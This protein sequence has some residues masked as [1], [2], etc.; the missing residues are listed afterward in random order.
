MKY[1][2]RTLAA[3][4]ESIRLIDEIV[5][6]FQQLKSEIQIYEKKRNVAKT[7]GTSV[8]VTGAVSGFIGIVLTA[9]TGNESFF[10]TLGAIGALGGAAI[11]FVVDIIDHVGSKEHF[12][13]IN[14][15]L[16]RY[17]NQHRKLDDLWKN[18]TVAVEEM[19][20]Q[21]DIESSTSLFVIQNTKD[22]WGR[23]ISLIS[24]TTNGAMLLQSARIID[25]LKGFGKLTRTPTGGLQFVIKKTH[26]T[27][28]EIEA[29]AKIVD[30]DIIRYAPSVSE[31]LFKGVV[32]L[33]GLI[34]SLWEVKNLI[35]SWIGSHPTIQAVDKVVHELEKKR[36]NLEHTRK[37]II[38]TKTD[39]LTGKHE[40]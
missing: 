6:V 4:E 29:L 37:E 27:T 24:S 5:V 13:R 14:C 39:L 31:P 35:D 8:G 23:A 1:V 10:L 32:C 22:N 12:K 28:T 33:A 19:K 38:R 17:N 40:L 34:V 26:L 11:N 25:T 30:S 18:I 3:H 36:S 9:L 7:V 2:D 21:H 15:Q 16:E 20:Q